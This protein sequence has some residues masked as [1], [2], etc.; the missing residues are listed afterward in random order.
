MARATMRGMDTS[1]PI[2]AI[3]EQGR[4]L[5]VAADKAGPDAEVPACP[6]WTVRTLLGHIGK[7]HRWAA[8][9]VREGRAATAGGKHPA[10]ATA[11]A[12]GLLDWLLG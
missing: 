4:A 7:V 11:P 2:D 5:A 9:H 3:E 12:D 10:L 6:T 1:T 8:T